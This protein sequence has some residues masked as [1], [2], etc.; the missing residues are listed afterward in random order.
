V[1]AT[2][3]RAGL[4]PW[5]IDLTRPDVGIPVVKAFVPGLCFRNRFAP[6]R[7]YDVPVTLGWL[8]APRPECA[9][10]SFPDGLL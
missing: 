9:L 7:L 1:Y 2:L 5:V 3:A 10:L 6:G 4:A 8:A